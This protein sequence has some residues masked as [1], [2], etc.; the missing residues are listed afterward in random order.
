MAHDNHDHGPWIAHHFDN[1]RQQFDAGKLGIWVFLVTEVLFFSGLFCAYVLYRASQPEIFVEASTHL[2]KVLGGLNTIV[3]LFS[4]LTMA[5]AVRAAQLNQNKTLILNL[6]ITMVCAA[7]FLGVKA[8]EYSH[9]WDEGILTRGYYNFHH[10]ETEGISKY[11]WML[12]IPPGILLIGFAAAAGLFKATNDAKKAYFFFGLTL[13]M[14]G[15]FL[16]AIAGKVYMDIKPKPAAHAGDHAH[17]DEHGDEHGDGDHD[18]GKHD[19]EKHGDGKSQASWKIGD[20][21]ITNAVFQEDSKKQD[22]GKSDDKK[23]ESKKSEND[24]DEKA[25][26]GDKSPEKNKGS[27]EDEK[28]SDDKMEAGD[29]SAVAA[30][31]EDP[32]LDSERKRRVGIF[33]S[34]YYCMTGLHAI[35]VIA[36]MIALSWLLWRA[37]HGHFRSDYFGPV[38]YVGLYWHLVDL[39]WIYLFP[40]LY[41]IN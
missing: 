40:L 36:G 12:S 16:G 34:I 18:D 7:M 8:V 17:D 27:G 30:S 24:Q 31:T 39:I 20:K 29:E 32:L 5:I 28:K 3:L 23:A 33:F 10:H 37:I 15:Y 26:T 41:L 21:E 25:K 9:K 22:D 19:D 4:S 38:D 1:P 11:L 14:G 35:H 6:M 13:M 2:D